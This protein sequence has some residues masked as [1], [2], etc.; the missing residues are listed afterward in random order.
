MAARADDSQGP[1]HSSAR[2]DHAHESRYG[3]A[4]GGFFALGTLSFDDSAGCRKRL[5]PRC[6]ATSDRSEPFLAL[7]PKFL[8]ADVVSVDG[9]KMEM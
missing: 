8:S 2:H 1:V 7:V 4:L 3:F 6:V 5:S 9:E